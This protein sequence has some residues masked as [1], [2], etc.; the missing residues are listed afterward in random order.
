MCLKLPS[1][2]CLLH[3]LCLLNRAFVK[4]D[5]LI[6]LRFFSSIGKIVMVVFPR[7]KVII[8]SVLGLFT[9]YRT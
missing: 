6:F 8:S 2:N 9:R 5:G 3:N 4:I 1:V 7:E